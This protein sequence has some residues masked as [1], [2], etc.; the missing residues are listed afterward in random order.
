M[1]SVSLI[2]K[3]FNFNTQFLGSLERL[4]LELV[5]ET[6]ECYVSGGAALAMYTGQ[7]HQI[8]D[9]DIFSES[10]LA[11]ISI[12][13]KLKRAGFR[14]IGQ[15]SAAVKFKNAS[16]EAH[17]VS[18]GGLIVD[19]M[20]SF[21]FS[22]CQV[23]F[24]G[25]KFLVNQ[26]SLEDIRMKRFNFVYTKFPELCKKRV[27]RYEQKGYSPSETFWDDFNRF[28]NSVNTIDLDLAY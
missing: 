26:G 18:A 3:P 25:K 4:I 16:V 12:C 9:Y 27:K 17:V 2:E 5:S 11:E 28:V 21:D 10:R 13:E 1:S 8:S 22:I 19:I 14:Q 24:D 15:T 20:K 23:A 7:R 6:P